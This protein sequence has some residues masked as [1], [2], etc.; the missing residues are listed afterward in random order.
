MLLTGKLN[1]LHH[2]SSKS[3][4]LL[5]QKIIKETDVCT[6]FYIFVCARSSLTYMVP[7]WL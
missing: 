2:F 3:Q 7:K 1:N 6:I 5:I 4:K